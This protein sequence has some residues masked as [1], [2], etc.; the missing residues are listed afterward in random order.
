MTV[1]LLLISILFQNT[2]MA[3]TSEEKELTSILETMRKAMVDADKAALEKIA[4]ENLSYGHSSGLVEDKPTFVHAIVSGKFGF[5]RLSFTDVTVKVMDK[6]AIVRH[7]MTG[8]ANNDGKPGPVNI[9][10]MLVF[11]KE[12]GGWKLVGRQAF[13]L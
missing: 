7:K 4:S 3:Q 11:Q 2:A 5:T 6:T 13:K 10:V 9:G 8:D 1:F 12:S